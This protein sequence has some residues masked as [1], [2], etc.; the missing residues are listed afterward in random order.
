MMVALSRK[1]KRVDQPHSKPSGWLGWGA[2]LRSRITPFLDLIRTADMDATPDTTPPIA[3]IRLRVGS[4]SVTGNYRAENEDRCYGDADQGIF[5][6]VDGMG[7]HLGGARAAETIVKVIPTHLKSRISSTHV[8]QPTMQ[9]AVE[10]AVELARDDMIRYAAQHADYFKMGATMALAVVVDE[11]LYF[12]HVGDCR[13]YHLR[14]GELYR[15]TS[16]QTLVQA[17]VDAGVLTEEEAE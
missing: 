15:M 14:Q 8:D 13:V 3:R 6:V 5:L 4:Q 16:D 11:V 12:T 17:L 2:R 10:E 7:G 1:S 9:Q